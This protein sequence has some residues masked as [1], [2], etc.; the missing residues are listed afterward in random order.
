MDTI[1]NRRRQR[2]ID[3]MVC[4]VAASVLIAGESRHFLASL[5]FRLAPS[6]GAR[7]RLRTEPTLASEPVNSGS[8]VIFLARNV[9]D[10]FS[11]A[12]ADVAFDR[13]ACERGT[14]FCGNDAEQKQSENYCDDCF[15]AAAAWPPSTA[16]SSKLIET[17]RVGHGYP[18]GRP[19]AG[20]TSDLGGVFLHSAV[21]RQMSD[22]NSR[23]AWAGLHQ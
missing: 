17:F 20:F 5:N 12:Q 2:L 7:C 10:A 6:R 8:V 1:Q 14:K 13:A 16:V 18:E 4:L 19:A 15:G 9:I 22:F 21:D 23:P 11:C 3:W